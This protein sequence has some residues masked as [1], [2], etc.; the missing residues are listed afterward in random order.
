MNTRYRKTGVKKPIPLKRNPEPKYGTT[1]DDVLNAIRGIET[2]ISGLE[3]A[4][5]DFYSVHMTKK[6]NTKLQALSSKKSG[7]IDHNT[8]RQMISFLYGLL[9]NPVE[10]L[11]DGTPLEY[12]LTF[13]E[14]WKDEMRISF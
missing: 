3:Q 13:S 11:F 5:K 7:M 6:L 12:Y 1:L 8:I 9:N 10:K 14:K 4:W 2:C